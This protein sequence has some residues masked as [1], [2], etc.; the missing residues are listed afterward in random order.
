[1]WACV[2]VYVCMCMCV[3]TSEQQVSCCC[4]YEKFMHVHV[5]GTLVAHVLCLAPDSISR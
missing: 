3:Y 2:C 5:Y 4:W 1:M